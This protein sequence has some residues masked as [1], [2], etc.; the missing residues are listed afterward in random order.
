MC[1]YNQCV[2]LWTGEK[3]DDRENDLVNQFW[4]M[5]SLKFFRT[6]ESI[7]SIFQGK[8]TNLT[9]FW[10]IIH[11]VS[12][13]GVSIE[14]IYLCDTFNPYHPNKIKGHMNFLNLKLDFMIL[15]R[16]NRSNLKTHSINIRLI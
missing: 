16:P 4:K 11:N 1:V 8:I 12:G 2:F 9:I 10:I 14:R 6:Y 3:M 15:S 7:L 5:Y 13:I